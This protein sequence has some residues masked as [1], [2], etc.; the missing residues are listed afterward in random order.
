MARKPKIGHSKSKNADFVATKSIGSPKIFVLDTNII[1]HDHHAVFNFQENDIYI[2]VTVIEELDK[3]K[4]GNDTL[5]YN[6]RSF[7]REMDK[8]STNSLFDKGASLGKGKGRIK[9]EMGR[10]I[11]NSFREALIDDIPDHRIIACAMSLRDLNPNRKVILVSKDINVRL[12]AKALGVL[13]QDYLTDKIDEDRIEKSGK[14]VIILRNNKVRDYSKIAESPNGL[15]LQE[16]NIK[17]R[18]YANQL[19]II[20]SNSLSK[21]NEHSSILARYNASTN[22]I[23]EVKERIAYGIEPRN[24]E[25][26]FALDAVLNPNIK[27]V[28]LTGRAGTGKTLIALAGALAQADKFDQILLS[29][30]VIPLK[31]QELGYLPGDVKDKIGP[32]M[33]PLFDNL[34]VIKNCFKP[35]SP[36]VVKIEDMLRREKLIINPLAYIRGR[37]LNKVFFII[38]ESQ[39]LTPHEVKTIIT[40][41][42]EGTKIIFTGDIFQ[43][44][45]PYLDINSNGLS[46]LGEKLYGETIFEHVNLQ[47]GERSELSEIAGKLL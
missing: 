21:V 6:A 32:Y 10:T 38:D 15:T 35:S 47:K 17:K 31:N 3:F 44:D 36:E 19:Y 39:N 29:R 1:L 16:L 8:L 40:R 9:I 13:A 34:S 23:I 46:H 27:L 11:S 28:S 4:K 24:A 26:T 43:I 5:S 45:Q 30:P 7:M 41:A 14:E 25:Q 42:G 18:P 20:P 2:P 22:S 33:L 37:S 12:K